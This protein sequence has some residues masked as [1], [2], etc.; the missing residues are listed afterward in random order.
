MGGRIPAGNHCH[1]CSI[2][3]QFSERLIDLSRKSLRVCQATT[4]MRV[5][6]Q[7]RVCAQNNQTNITVTAV[8]QSRKLS[9]NEAAS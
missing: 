3:T 5:D 8:R 4:S 1:A 2:S 7:K 6:T 9:L